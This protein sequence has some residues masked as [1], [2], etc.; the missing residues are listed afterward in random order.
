MIDHDGGLFNLRKGKTAL[1]KLGPKFGRTAG[2]LV[3]IDCIIGPDAED[4]AQRRG[5]VTCRCKAWQRYCI[6]P[7]NRA[8]FNRQRYQVLTR[9]S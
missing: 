3:G 7:V 2:D 9:A 1:A 5:L 6:K 8:G 4:F